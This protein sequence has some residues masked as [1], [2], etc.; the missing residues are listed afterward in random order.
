MRAS[1]GLPVTRETRGGKP[2]PAVER[3]PAVRTVPWSAVPVATG[4]SHEPVFRYTGASVTD[5][6]LQQPCHPC[7]SGGSPSRT[8][9]RVTHPVNSTDRPSTPQHGSL[10]VIFLTVFIDLLG[11]GIV[12][13]LLPIYGEQFATQHGFTAGPGRLDGRPADGQFLGHAVLFSAGVGTPVRPVRASSHSARGPGRFHGV[14]HLVRCGHGLGQPGLVVRGADRCGHRRCHDF[15]R[16]GVHCR[17]HVDRES[18]ER[19]GAHR[20]CLCAWASPWGR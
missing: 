4:A 14:L 15:D 10:F 13:P 17:H 16:A 12:L 20:G 11:F 6:Q 9:A 19:H 18:H 2:A 3:E 5:L 7:A 8:T 1:Y